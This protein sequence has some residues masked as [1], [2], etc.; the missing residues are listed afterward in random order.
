VRP[1]PTRHQ[2]LAAIVLLAVN[3]AIV[4]PLFRIEYLEHTGSIAGTMIGLARLMAKHPGEWAWWPYWNGGLPFENV[5]LPFTHW[6]VAALTALTGLSAARSFHIFSAA[7]YTLGSLSLFALA[8]TLSRKLWPSFIA[9]LMWSTVSLSTLLIPAV[10]ADAGDP[11]YLRRLQILV[12]YGEAPHSHALALLAVAILCLRRALDGGSARWKVA[13]GVSAAAVVLSNAFGIFVLVL[14]VAAL[15]LAY[16]ST[17]W[18]RALAT[19]AAIGLASFCWVSPWLSPSMLR[20][21][22]ANSAT[23]GGDF[24]YTTASWIALGILLAGYLALSFAMQ[25]F[26]IAPHL[27]FFTLLAW[28][29]TGFLAIWYGWDIPVIPQPFRYQLELDMLLPLVLVF[30]CAALLERCPKPARMAAVGITL[31][32]LALQTAGAVSFARRL[33]RPVDPATLSEYRVATWLERN[34]P[35]D[36]AY[37]TGSTSQLFN[38][39]TD[40]PQLHG[41]HDQHTINTFIAIVTFTLQTDMNAGARAAECSVAWLKA[42]GVR[43]VHIAGPGS[44]DFYKPFAHPGKF[45]GVLPLLWRDRGDSLY[46]VP[47]RSPSLAHVIPAS[48]V[49]ARRPLHGLDIAAVEPYLAALDDPAN[50]VASFRWK[51]TSEAEIRA[52]IAPGQLISVQETYTPGWEAWANGKRQKVR[53]DALGQL[54]IEPECAGTCDIALRYTGGVEAVATRSLSLAAT[55]FAAWALWRGRRSLVP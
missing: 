38:A 55:F 44:T 21:L 25:R 2:S 1:G 13:A 41:G 52:P 40:N 42:F 46:E 10:R 14:S 30:G 7:M 48:A 36:R 16:R 3:L 9:A 18:W 8:V 45:D 47:S 4:G 27:Q 32:V 54:V 43:Q 6:L 35:G 23:T 31:T 22:R 53:G 50:P 19:A 15:L 24:R 12:F 51:S 33:I 28:F 49:V 26:T 11:L 5:Y 29:P 39:F 17:P 34:R 20:A 37:L